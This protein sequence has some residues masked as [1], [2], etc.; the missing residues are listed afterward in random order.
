MGEDIPGFRR[1]FADSCAFCMTQYGNFSRA[2]DAGQSASGK[3][4]EAWDIR[5]EDV[6]DGN[7]L[8]L[9]TLSTGKIVLRAPDGS[10]IETFP[11]EEGIT[12]AWTLQSKPRGWIVTSATDLP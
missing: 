10:V 2:Y 7:A 8:A 4:Y 11:A 1:K 3:L 5:V 9:T 6:T 12:T